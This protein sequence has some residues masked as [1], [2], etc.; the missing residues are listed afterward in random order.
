ML[1]GVVV[2]QD[3]FTMLNNGWDKASDFNVQVSGEVPVPSTFALAG[4][5]LFGVVASRRRKA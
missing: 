1:N 4:L 5:A 3:A 2:S